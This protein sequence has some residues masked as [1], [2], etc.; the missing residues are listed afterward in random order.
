MLDTIGMTDID[1]TGCRALGEVLDDLQASHITFG[2]ARGSTEL[3]ATLRKE[4]LTERIGA[5]HCFDS[6]NE[7][8]VALA[9]AAPAPVTPATP[10]PT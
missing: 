5:D 8:V 10:P 2:I 1:F 6:V 4:G 7:A 9:G 3:L